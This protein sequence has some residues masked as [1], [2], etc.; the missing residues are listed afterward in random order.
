MYRG[1]IEVEE[2]THP[3]LVRDL[4]VIPGGGGAGRFRGAP[5][6]EV[7]YGPRFDPMTVVIMCDGQANPPQGVRGGHAGPCAETWHVRADGSEEKL[8]GVVECQVEPGEWIRGVDAGGGGYGSP[9]E[10]EPAR[11]LKD[12]LARWETIERAHDI[13]GVV[14]SGTVEDESLAVDEA[15]TSKRRAE[16]Q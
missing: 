15:A 2:S 4:R 3:L 11:V 13:Y 12:V 1:S 14:F 6:A 8:P 7:I 9:L 10:R 5:G 16:L